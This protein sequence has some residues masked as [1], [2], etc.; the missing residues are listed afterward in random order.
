VLTVPA[1]MLIG[2]A[3]AAAGCAATTFMRSWTDFDKIALVQLPLFLF[4]GTFFPVSLYPAPLRWVA[5]ASPLYRG[6]HLLRGLT[7]GELNPMLLVDVAYLVMIGLV[8]V[9]I[10][11]RRL[12]KLLLT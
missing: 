11:E 7:L 1:A 8:G 4:S 10:V 9:L 5:E 3:F 6:V 12:R 2:L